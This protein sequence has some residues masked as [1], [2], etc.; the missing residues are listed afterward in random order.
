LGLTK[1]QGPSGTDRREEV[2]IMADNDQGPVPGGQRRLDG[3]DRLEIEVVRR[4]IQ[5]Q[6][7]RR[8]ATC[9]DAG[10]TRPQSLTA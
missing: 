4:L 8:P 2:R 10:Q 5:D 1:G 9:H 3:R 7:L 6:Q